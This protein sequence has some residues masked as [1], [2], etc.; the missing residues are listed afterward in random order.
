MMSRALD[1]GEIG[2]P[3]THLDFAAFATFDLPVKR[4]LVG[5][6][7]FGGTSDVSL[8]NRAD[9]LKP[10]L[11]AGAPV[12]DPLFGATVQHDNCFDTQLKPSMDFTR[13]VIAKPQKLAGSGAANRAPLIGNQLYVGSNLR[14]DQMYMADPTSFYNQADRG[15]ATAASVAQSVNAFDPTK[16]AAF[17]G[18]CDKAGVMDCARRQAGLRTWVTPTGSF[19]GRTVYTDRNLRIGGDGTGTPGLHSGSVKIGIGLIFEVVL[20]HAEVDA[21]LDYTSAWLAEWYDITDV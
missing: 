14:G 20:T 12:I 3:G 8:I 11:L 17:V 16:W 6:Y 10:L 21:N 13:I 5:A 2:L 9:P 7:V 15:T 18:I 1:L 4:G 19:T